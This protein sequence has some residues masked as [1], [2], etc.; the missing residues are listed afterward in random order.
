MDIS[1][2]DQD[3]N[4]ILPTD[5]TPATHPDDAGKQTLNVTVLDQ[6]L[7][8]ELVTADACRR[9][10][11][12]FNQLP[13]AEVLRGVMV[14]HHQRAQVLRDIIRSNQGIPTELHEQD[15]DIAALFS[16][17]VRLVF[18]LLLD[19]EHRGVAEYR[20]ALRQL[21]DLTRTQVEA[22]LLPAQERALATLAGAQPPAADGSV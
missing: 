21:D 15:S 22:E 3:L 13:V 17:N 12:L 19:L 1:A 2:N 5:P 18:A 11:V 14:G 7:A 8:T 10:G 4:V 6:L 9:A 16:A 20:Q